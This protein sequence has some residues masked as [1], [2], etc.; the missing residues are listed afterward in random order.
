MSKLRLVAISIPASPPAGKKDLYLRSTDNAFVGIDENGIQ[1]VLGKTPR[2]T[3]MVSAAQPIINTSYH[4]CVSITAQAEA[5]TSMTAN[6]TGSMVNFQK[7]IIR[8]KDNGVARAITWGSYF[9]SKG[10]DLPTV[11]T[12]GKVS[13][14][15]LIFDSVTNKWGCVAV[16]TEA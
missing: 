12:A 14:I 7:L 15:G 9:E 8:I 5:I 1:D 13:T 2:V 11:T 16:Q 4:D 3:S 10:K 6:L